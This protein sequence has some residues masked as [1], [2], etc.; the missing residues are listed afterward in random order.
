MKIFEFRKFVTLKIKKNKKKFFIYI[1]RYFLYILK[2]YIL[3]SR[4][5]F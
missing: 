1:N 3:N 2:V 5:I 4:L